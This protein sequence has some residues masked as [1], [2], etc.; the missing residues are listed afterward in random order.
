MLRAAA[1]AA[2]ARPWAASLKPA[3]SRHCV[4]VCFEYQPEEGLEFYELISHLPGERLM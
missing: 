1:A 2:L 4:Q 3:A